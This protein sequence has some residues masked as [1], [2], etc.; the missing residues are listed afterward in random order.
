MPEHGGGLEPVD[1]D[2]ALYD[3][4]FTSAGDKRRFTEIRR[5]TPDQL[6]ASAPR[7]VFDDERFTEMLFRFRARNWPETLSVDEQDAWRRH[8]AARLL[9]GAAGSLTVDRYF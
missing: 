7:I 6:A 4:G 8:C 5:S 1:V 3:G 9:K 2:A